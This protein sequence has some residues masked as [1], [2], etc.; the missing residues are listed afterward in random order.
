MSAYFLF[1]ILSVDLYITDITYTCF[2]I[3]RMIAVFIFRPKANVFVIQSGN[4]Q[5][6]TNG[7]GHLWLLFMPIV[8]QPNRCFQPLLA[9]EPIV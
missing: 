7:R 9:I 6:I 3:D 8:L 5:I 1:V 4:Y 2:I